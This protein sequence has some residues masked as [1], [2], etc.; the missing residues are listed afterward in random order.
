MDILRYKVIFTKRRKL[1]MEE[2]QICLGEFKM[3]ED[4]IEKDIVRKV[5]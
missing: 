2:N 1:Q 5:K 3:I 4:Y